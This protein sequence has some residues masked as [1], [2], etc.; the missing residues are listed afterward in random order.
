MK[1]FSSDPLKIP[2]FSYKIIC[3]SWL[4]LSVMSGKENYIFKVIKIE[5]DIK[6]LIK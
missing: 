2:V 1:S 4:Y 3:S 6:S 5:I